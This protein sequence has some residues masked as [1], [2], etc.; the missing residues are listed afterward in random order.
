[1]IQDGASP[2]YKASEVGHDDVIQLL[3]ANGASVDLPAKV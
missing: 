1:M 3:L 2:L